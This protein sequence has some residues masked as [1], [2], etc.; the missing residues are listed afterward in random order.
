MLTGISAEDLLQ[1]PTREE[2]QETVKTFFTPNT[3]IIGHSV[4]FD[5]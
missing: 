1:A 5:I 2:L 3:V 4:G